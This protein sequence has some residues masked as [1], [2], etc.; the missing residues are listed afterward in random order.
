[1]TK[2]ESNELL[3]QSSVQYREFWGK[4]VTK[5][6]KKLQQ[7]SLDKLKSK[8]W[9]KQKQGLQPGQMREL[10]DTSWITSENVRC[11][12]AGCWETCIWS[13]R[14]TMHSTW[15]K[16]CWL[17]T[18]FQIKG[19]FSK[20]PF[21]QADA[22]WINRAGKESTGRF[23]S[24]LSEHRNPFPPE[25]VKAKEAQT[26]LREGEEQSSCQHRSWPW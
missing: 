3:G 7:K 16:S 14:P 8:G 20:Y 21:F 1:M 25:A 4:R 18:N 2:K 10:V 24:T 15:I 23:D 9:G 11:R 6:K 17:D 12:R 26:N 19:H 13:A 5:R 22:W